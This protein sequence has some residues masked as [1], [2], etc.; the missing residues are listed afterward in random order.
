MIYPTTKSFN[1]Q[2][3][4][5][6]WRYPIQLVALDNTPALIYFVYNNDRLLLLGHR[7]VSSVMIWVN[8]VIRWR[9]DWGTGE[10]RPGILLPLALV[11]ALFLRDSFWPKIVTHVDATGGRCGHFLAPGVDDWSVHFLVSGH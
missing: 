10:C 6:M 9:L 1:S 8:F 2:L 5:N 11:I 3:T 4:H 7:T